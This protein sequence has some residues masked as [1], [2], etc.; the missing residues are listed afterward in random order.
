MKTIA[1]RAIDADARS[2]IEF[3]IRWAPVGGSSTGDLLMTF[4][5]GRRRLMTLLQEGVRYRPGG[6]AIARLLE[7]SFWDALTSRWRG[8]ARLVGAHRC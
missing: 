6:N 4:G 7:R 8:D 2:V 5:V 3:A 1:R